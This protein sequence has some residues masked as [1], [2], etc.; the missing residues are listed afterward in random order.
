[1]IGGLGSAVAEQKT[2]LAGTPP[3]LILG[4]P[5]EHGKAGEYKDILERSGLTPPEIAR[6]IQERLGGGATPGILDD[7]ATKFR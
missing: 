4:L 3:Q 2:T 7:L 1:V 6:K 5:D